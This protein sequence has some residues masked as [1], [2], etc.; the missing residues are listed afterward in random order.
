MTT[1]PPAEIVTVG[2]VSVWLLSV[3]D[4]AASVMG[5]EVALYNSTHSLVSSGQALGE[6]YMTS[7]ITTS[8]RLSDGVG[9]LGVG[10]GGHVGVGVPVGVAVIIG[11][12]EGVAVAVL[13]TVEV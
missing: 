11:V 10:E 6:S 2:I 13:V 9:G 4:Q 1:N 7:L 3:I 8:P 12:R 5:E